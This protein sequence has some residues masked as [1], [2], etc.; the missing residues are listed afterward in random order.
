M[1]I[2]QNWKTTSAGLGAIV[3]ATV[4]LVAA[5]V[6]HN[7]TQGLWIAS[8]SGIITGIGLIFAGDASAGEKR[9]DALQDKVKT[10]IETDDTSH[11]NKPVD[12]KA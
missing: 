7:S 5:I 11:L 3:T 6:E 9:V 4:P 10:A 2:F 12:P 1:K 8:L